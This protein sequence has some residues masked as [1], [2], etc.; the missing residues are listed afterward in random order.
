MPREPSF[1]VNVPSR[2]DPSAA[3]K[4]KDSIV[5]LVPV[6]HLLSNETMIKTFKGDEKA[7]SQDWDSLV[8]RARQQVIHTMETRLGITGLRE[9]IT[10]EG[11][12]TPLTCEFH[13]FCKGW[14][15]Y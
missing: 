13:T 9:K 15:E 7:P 12:N 2:V 6:G 5:V 1:Y 4:D 10:W 11:V 14:M 8:E 3:P